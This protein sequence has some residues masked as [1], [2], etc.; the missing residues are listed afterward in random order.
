MEDSM[1]LSQAQRWE[2][3]VRGKCPIIG[4]SFF[5]SVYL[6]T[7]PEMLKNQRGTRGKNAVPNPYVGRLK[8]HCVIKGDCLFGP[9]HY[10]AYCRNARRKEA[11]AMREDGFSEAEISAAG[12][13]EPESVNV[14]KPSGRHYMQGWLALS[15]S[16]KVEGRH[17]VHLYFPRDKATP[18]IEV[19]YELDGRYVEVTPESEFAPFLKSDFF[20]RKE[21]T[22]KHGV[23]HATGKGLAPVTRT[24]MLDSVQFVK[25]GDFT[26]GDAMPVPPPT[27]APALVEGAEIA[28]AAAT[29]EEAEEATQN[30]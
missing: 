4:G 12:L 18:R 5:A 14:A 24:P 26:V 1:N 21:V 6:V 30:N 16:D 29:V 11:K 9:T 10:A 20:D 3:Y 25:C 7:D 27:P 15:E 8:K 2:N 19:W 17:Y 22:K 13:A 28:P 23:N